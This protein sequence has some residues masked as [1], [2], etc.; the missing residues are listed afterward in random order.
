MAPSQDDVN[1][2]VLDM[3]FR[4]SWSD[5]RLRFLEPGLGVGSVHLDW[6][7]VERIWVPDT[8]FT[9]T[10][11]AS[12]HTIP[13]PNRPDETRNKT[14]WMFTCCHFTTDSFVLRRRV[15]WSTLND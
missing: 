4:Q 15:A 1:D 13:V 8:V 5:P 7:V 2:L 11:A 14:Y 3:Y 9:N 10:R 12:L 6:R